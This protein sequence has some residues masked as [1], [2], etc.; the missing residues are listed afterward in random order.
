MLKFLSIIVLVFP[1]AANGH[2]SPADCLGYLRA[3]WLFERDTGATP[4]HQEIEVALSKLPVAEKGRPWRNWQEWLD[5]WNSVDWARDRQRELDAED[6]RHRLL[7]TSVPNARIKRQVAFDASS[8]ARDQAAAADEEF[9]D[10]LKTHGLNAEAAKLFKQF[11]HSYRD[12]RETNDVHSF[13]AP[14]LVFRVAVHERQTMC[15]P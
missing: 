4:N 12:T 10:W 1:V 6:R 11:V 15:P 5:A 8:K 2:E 14:H 9:D 7:G 13:H 3:E